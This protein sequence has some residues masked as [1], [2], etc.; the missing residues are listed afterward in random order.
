MALERTTTAP[1]LSDFIAL[2]EYESQT[3]SSF[4]SIKPILHFHNTNAD[5]KISPADLDSQPALLELRNLT[6]VSTGEDGETVFS[7]VDVWVTST[8]LTL[9][10]PSMVKGAQI[11]YPTITVHAQDGRGVLLGL[12]LSD[13]ETADEDVVFVQLRVIPNISEHRLA[14][15]EVNSEN[16]NAAAQ[17]LFKAISDCQELNPDPPAAGDS[18]EEGGMGG[19]GFDE[20]APGATGWITSENMHEFVGED[21]EFRLAE[22]TA[23]F[24]ADEGEGLGEGA[25]RTRTAAEVNGDGDEV[26][27]KWQ[28]TG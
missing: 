20:T 12:N 8:H 23:V 19:I 15:H 25:G 13:S 7:G 10:S 6:F 27:G 2:A 5:I 4:A 3:P 14:G 9:F 11:A 18:D 28:R 24:G 26:E 21:G 1:Q 17:V 22:G 16:P